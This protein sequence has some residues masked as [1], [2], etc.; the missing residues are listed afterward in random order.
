MWVMCVKGVPS[1]INVCPLFLPP[2]NQDEKNQSLFCLGDI[3]LT[4]GGALGSHGSGVAFV[5]GVRRVGQF[6]AKAW[7]RS[8]ES[9]SERGNLYRWQVYIL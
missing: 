3:A 2:P 1:K 4:G 9:S 8:R 5:K 7:W 6:F